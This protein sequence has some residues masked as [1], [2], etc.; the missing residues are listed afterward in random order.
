MYNIIHNVDIKKIDNSQLNHTQCSSSSDIKRLVFIYYLEIGKAN[1][2]LHI[3]R[4][5]YLPTF[6]SPTIILLSLVTQI[7]YSKKWHVHI[8]LNNR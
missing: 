8:I 5:E 3:V 1:R 6:A 4:D 2:K 7:R